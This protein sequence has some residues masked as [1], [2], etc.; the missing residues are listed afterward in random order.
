MEFPGSS[1]IRPNVSISE[2][3]MAAA[4]GCTAAKVTSD[5]L[6]ATKETS[7]YK[8]PDSATERSMRT[9]HAERLSGLSG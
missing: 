9:A 6:Y 1:A 7:A 5:G 3:A 4:T 8:S 2:G